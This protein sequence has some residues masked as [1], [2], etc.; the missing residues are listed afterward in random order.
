MQMHAVRTHVWA[1]D[2]PT[3]PARRAAASRVDLPT[4]PR[5]YR[6]GGPTYY[7]KT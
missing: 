4:Y 6:L 3:Y 1:S 7:E 5:A 2:L